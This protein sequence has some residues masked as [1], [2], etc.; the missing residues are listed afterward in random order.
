MKNP[1]HYIIRRTSDFDSPASHDH[2]ILGVPS[3]SPGLW[4]KLS[5]AKPDSYFVP[6]GRLSQVVDLEGAELCV[7]LDGSDERLTLYPRFRIAAVKIPETAFSALRGSYD[8]Q[9]VHVRQRIHDIFNAA[10]GLAC[11]A[12]TLDGIAT[13]ESARHA[14][15]EGLSH[16]GILQ[17]LPDAIANELGLKVH[18]KL[19]LN[20]TASDWIKSLKAALSSKHLLKFNEKSRTSQFLLTYSIKVVEVKPASWVAAH[21]RSQNASNS[22]DG[23]ENELTAVHGLVFQVLDPAFGVF[24]G[25]EKPWEH[26]KFWQVIRHVFDNLVKPRLEREFGYTVEFSDFKRERAVAEIETLELLEE[27]ERLQRDFIYSEQV[28]MELLDKRKEAIIAYA[29]VNSSELAEIDT[30][31]ADAKTKM[32][33]AQRKLET[34]STG[35]ASSLSALTDKNWTE[36]FTRFFGTLQLEAPESLLH[37][38]LEDQSSN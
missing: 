28:Y 26:P 17:T 35:T 16:G 7:L 3:S 21:R 29:E 27:K 6:C 9:L 19:E 25:P 30:K 24:G 14:Q 4:A 20:Q 33:D 32:E 38:P 23:I 10:L 2:I 11:N 15:F 37:L 22:K 1:L 18:W 12:Q 34:T 13:H 31:V 5:G 8:S 36:T